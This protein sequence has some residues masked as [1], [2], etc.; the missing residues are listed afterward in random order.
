MVYD[1]KDFENDP[2]LELWEEQR[3]ER[4]FD[5]RELWDLDNTI[6]QFILPRLK[7][8]KPYTGSYPIGL[9]EKKWNHILKEMIWSFEL[10][11]AGEEYPPIEYTEEQRVLWRHRKQR[12]LN[13]F[14]KYLSHLWD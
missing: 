7:A 2:R 3:K 1:D 4:G 10:V 8:F 14:A 6:A 13:L 9:T 12:G 11:A 5:D